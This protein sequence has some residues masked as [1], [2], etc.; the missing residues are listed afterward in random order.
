MEK[1]F[2]EALVETCTVSFCLRCHFKE[3]E[4][5]SVWCQKDIK[6]QWPCH[7]HPY[8]IGLSRTHGQGQYQLC[9]KVHTFLGGW[10]WWGG[11][12]GDKLNN[13]LLQLHAW[14]L[15]ATFSTPPWFFRSHWLHFFKR[16][17]GRSSLAF[18]SC[19]RNTGKTH[20]INNKI[21]SATFKKSIK[22][23][24]RWFYHCV[25]L[26]GPLVNIVLIR[27]NYI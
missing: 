22:L 2:P 21:F 27:I 9:K 20:D 15:K 13:N 18:E 26:S 14:T 24:D 10:G 23:I 19:W 8:A 5:N 16:Q 25:L 7:F 12:S 1:K 4:A 3:G 11:R 6:Q 17:S